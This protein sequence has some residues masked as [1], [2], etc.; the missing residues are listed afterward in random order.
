[1]SQYPLIA[2][3]P[4]AHRYRAV[5]LDIYG[6]ILRIRTMAGS[7]DEEA[8]GIARNML[9]G[10]AIELWDGDRFIERLGPA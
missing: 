4:E 7:D 9:D 10:R 1:M 5:L 2:G 8:L 6:K 3:P